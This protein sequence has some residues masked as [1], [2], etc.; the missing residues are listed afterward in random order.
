MALLKGKQRKISIDFFE[1]VLVGIYGNWLISLL[2]NI[3]FAMVQWYHFILLCLSFVFLVAYFLSIILAGYKKYWTG[4]LAFHYSTWILPYFDLVGT[5]YQSV[6]FSLVGVM[7]FVSIYIVE[8][9]RS[10]QH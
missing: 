2:D 5:N 1:G 4:L 7:F 3:D 8:T 9:R 6:L 10:K